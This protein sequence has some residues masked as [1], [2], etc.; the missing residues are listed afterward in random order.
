MTCERKGIDDLYDLLE[1]YPN[2]R[3]INFSFNKIS[4]ISTIINIK[5]LT[6]LNLSNN[7]IDNL[8]TFN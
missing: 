7:D 6:V 8:E 5:Y 3:R 2:M 1:N 4:D